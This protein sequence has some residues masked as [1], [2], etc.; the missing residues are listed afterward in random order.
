MSKMAL[1]GAWKK[2]LFLKRLRN[3]VL[4]ARM[5]ETGRE[6]L[7]HRIR[8]APEDEDTKLPKVTRGLAREPGADHELLVFSS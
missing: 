5:S 2:N 7:L 4:K 1:E 3:I 6:H 8:Q